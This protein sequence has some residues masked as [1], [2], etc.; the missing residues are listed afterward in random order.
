MNQR[1]QEEHE[2]LTPE[3]ATTPY[4]TSESADDI[5]KRTHRYW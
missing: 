5:Q 1:D 4:P 3:S 2:K